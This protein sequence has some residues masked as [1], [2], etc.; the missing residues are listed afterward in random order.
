MKLVQ[1][2]VFGDSI[3]YGAWDTHGG[4]VQR[5]RSFI[6]QKN[7]SDPRYFCLVFNQGISGDKSTDLLKRMKFETEQRLDEDKP[8]TVFIIGIGGNDSVF[9]RDIGRNRT[10]EKQYEANVRRI[11]KIAKAYTSKIVFV[12]L[13]P[14]DETKSAPVPWRKNLYYQN[15]YLKRYNRIA[16]TVC[17]GEEV[18]FVELFDKFIKRKNYQTLLEDG[19]HPTDVGHE[20]I[21]KEVKSLLVRKKWI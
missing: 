14:A 16:K 1:I 4:W 11:I 10:T 18:Q 21:F 13:L 2:L 6:D 9:D 5:L 3:T 17:S 20:M 19:L 7:I 15:E 8:E 12:G